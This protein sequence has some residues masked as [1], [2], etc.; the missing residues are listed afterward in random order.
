ME[1]T[2]AVY[3]IKSQINSEVK[4]F[5]CCIGVKTPRV[6]VPPSS[7]E[8]G[9][10]KLPNFFMKE[11]VSVGKMLLMLAIAFPLGL[12]ITTACSFFL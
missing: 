12:G 1:T 4:R 7:K 8:T 11:D 10:P 9:F 3:S 6:F 2:G 5:D